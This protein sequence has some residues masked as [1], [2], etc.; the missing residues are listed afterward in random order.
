MTSATVRRLLLALLFL[1]SPVHHLPSQ[2]LTSATVVGTVTDSSGAVVPGAT[3]RILQP[4]TDAT[5]TAISGSTGEYRFPFLKPGEYEITAE[6]SGLSSA[7]SRLRLLVGQEQSVNLTLGV[8]SVQQSV[9]VVD[10]SSGLLQTENAN[11]ATSYNQQFIENT[12]INGGDITNIA[13][14]TPGLRLNVGGGNT[15]F[16][17]NG[18]PFSSVLFTMNGADIVEPYNLNNKS[19]ASNNTLGANDVAEAAVIV[20]AFSTQYGR[21]AGAQVNYISKSGANRLHGNLV[22]NYNGQFLNANDYINNSNHTPRGRSVAN[23]YAASIGGPI[24]R[25]KIFFYVNTE[26]LRYALP[27]SGVVSLPSPQLQSYILSQ[28]PAASQPLYKQ[29]FALYNAAPGISRAVPVTTGTGTLQDASGNLGCGNQT[30]GTAAHGAQFGKSGGTPC[31]I[32]FGTNASSVNTEY[33]VSGRADWNINDKQ[34]LYFRISRDAGAQASSTSPISPIYN[35]YSIQPWVIPQLNYTYA[36]T[37]NIVNNFV[38]SGNFYSAIFGVTN[39]PQS[40]STLSQAFAFTDG[41]ANGSTTTSSGSTT[42]TTTGFAFVGPALPTG[43]RGQQLQV[44]DDLSWT[45]HKHTLQAGINNRNNRITD[46]SIASNSIVGTY[47]FADVTDFVTGVVNSTGKNSKYVQAFPLVQAN[48]TRLNSLNF[49]GQDEWKVTKKLNV[50]YGVRFELNGNPSCKENCYSLFNAEF[51]STNYKAGSLVPY[52]QTIQTGV[53]KAFRNLEGIITEPRLG[54]AFQPFGEGNMV[55]RGGVGLFAN[56]FAG[57]L[58]AN[59]FGN[60]P[61]KFQPNV[62]AGNVGVSSDP[63][64]SQSIDIAS[65]QAFQGGFANGYTLA[66]LQAATGGRFSAPTYYT[67]PDNFKSIKVLEWSVEVEQPLTRHDVFALSYS[68][69]HSYSQPLSNTIANAYATPSKYPSGFGP[70]PTAIPDLRFATVTQILLSGYSNYNGLTA[71]VRHAMNYGFQAQGSYTWSKSLQIGAN[72]TTTAIIYN[73]YDLRSNY[74]P[75]SFDT[76]H[77]FTADILWN[78]PRLTN[79]LLNSTLSGWTV[80]GKIYLYSGRPFSAINS[81]IPGQLSSTFGGTVLAQP[82]DPSVVGTHCS[83][84]SV[85]T[86]CLK[87]SQFQTTGTQ[88]S[89]ATVRPN[90]FRGP[91][92]FTTAAHLA[93]VVPV[94]EQ[95]RFELGADAYNLLNHANFAVPSNDVSKGSVGLIS[96]TVSSPTSIYGTGQGALVSGRVL[97]V[98]GKFIF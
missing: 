45:M 82:I 56:T 28:I 76:R 4:E 37:P 75:T 15:N 26:G 20:N 87:T 90:S 92:F 42:T 93:K 41:G 63:N 49:Y 19:G 91:G 79:R 69:N 77:N 6:A 96:S 24:K 43:R 7:K 51:L 86:P 85:T 84:S 35:K 1:F 59:V 9:E 46:S 30:F 22:E 11:S 36:I 33:L 12:P 66:Q 97:V 54:V 40:Q 83:R 57:S 73:P 48:H 94:R 39:F 44:I 21:E 34:K 38:A 50:T 80:S 18:L 95:M 61:N 3:V 17:V 14:S 78:S 60:P 64:S 98:F 8:Q 71:Q 67:N 88:T 27:S 58:A 2:T 70:L 55:I 65:N 13:F 5:R 32:A 74:G 53:N 52:N 10:T 68:G 31:A 16:N 47:T 25:D 72:N 23:Q 81:Q 89:F 62:T 29:L